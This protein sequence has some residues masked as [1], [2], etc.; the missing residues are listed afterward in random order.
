M[1]YILFKDLSDSIRS[2]TCPKDGWAELRS[3]LCADGAML[4]DVVDCDV[5]QIP[6]RV[7]R[8]A[9]TPRADILHPAVVS[10]ALAS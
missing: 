8:R 3:Q 4:L 1:L 7:D 5:P 9:T 6:R 2:T 10:M